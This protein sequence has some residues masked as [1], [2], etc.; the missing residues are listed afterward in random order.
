M[1][2][3]ENMSKSVSHDIADLKLAP[4][5]KKKIEWAGQNSPVLNLITEEFSRTKPLKGLTI[6]AC[7]HVTSETANLMLAYVAGGAKVILCAS[8][9]LSTQ[10]MVAASLVVDYGIPVFAIHGEDKKTYYQHLNKVLDFHPNLT[11]DDGA[12]LVSL[13]HT[14][15][16]KQLSELI[17]SAEETTTGVIR[18]KAMAR[19]KALKIPV[20]AVNES[21]TK[22]LFDNRYG[23]GQSTVDGIIRTTNIL[24]AGKRVVVCGYGWCSRGIASRMRGMGAIVTVTE[25]DAVKALEAVM[26]GFT[27]DQI[28]RAVRYG[29]VFVSATGDKQVITLT[30]M[31]RM[32]D[33]AILANSGHF[34]VE[35]DYDGLVKIAKSRRI[36]RNNLEEI[37]LP[38]GKRLYALGEGRLIN[39]AGAEGH[40]AEVMDMSFA[41]QALGAAWFVKR[42]GTLQPKV[43]VL[44]KDVDQRVAR[45]KLRAMGMRFDR[46]TPV[47]RKYL[48]SWQEGT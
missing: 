11:T 6:G 9:P 47:Q 45:L 37:V 10:D 40:P 46:L 15:R 18:L 12:D 7:L 3:G 8:N 16:T 38:T 23:T 28:G 30:H 35:F 27:V 43:Y 2:K 13:L 36:L 39:L 24:L 44:P 42:K 4:E 1:L 48:H 22:H 34:N 20:L 19:D 14:E 25:V 26:D 29:E 33:G 21:D 41:N 32:K 17:G 31:K 5:G